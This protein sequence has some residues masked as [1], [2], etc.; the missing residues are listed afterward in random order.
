MCF[1]VEC[2][3]ALISHCKESNIGH[4]VLLILVIFTNQYEPLNQ[5]SV[6]FS[7][8]VTTALLDSETC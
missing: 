3:F 5:Y 7:L 2:V 1:A 4:V 6:C 8:D